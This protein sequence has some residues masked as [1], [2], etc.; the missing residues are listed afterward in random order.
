MVVPFI[1]GF[2]TEGPWRRVPH[3][4][5]PISLIFMQF[6]ATILSN[7]R[8]LCKFRGWGHHLGNTGCATAFHVAMSEGLCNCTCLHYL[9]S[10]RTFHTLG[11][12]III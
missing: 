11:T 8:F 3:Y 2:K 4:F 6:S 5:S 9:H 12:D 10:Q 1:G 7:N